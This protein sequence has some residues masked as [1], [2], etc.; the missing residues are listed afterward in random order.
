MK[1]KLYYRPGT[2][3]IAPYLAL[4]EAGADY[5][6]IDVSGRPEFLLTINPRGRVPALEVDGT[7]L[8][9]NTAILYFIAR[10]FPDAKLLPPGL[11]QEAQCI[12]TAAWFASMLHVNY[13][14]FLKPSIYADPAA[15]AD[16]S[17]QG[18]IHYLRDLDEIEQRLG[19]APWMQGDRFSFADLYGLVFVEW[20]ETSGLLDPKLH[21]IRAWKVRVIQ[22]PAVRRVLEKTDNILLKSA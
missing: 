20:A 22:R 7:V 19:K 1:I 14:R 8:V 2:C 13:R 5:E 9:E 6:V 17:E 16:I 15:H 12:S 11:M 18:R 3:A 4:E 10:S 21:H